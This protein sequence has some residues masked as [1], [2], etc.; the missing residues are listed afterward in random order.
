MGVLPRGDARD[1]EFLARA[2]LG[3]KMYTS[4]L[5]AVRICIVQVI[6]KRMFRLYLN[7]YLMT[8]F[9]GK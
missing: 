1:V 7:E 9:D 8:D 6:S 2:M 5:M 4:R 3:L